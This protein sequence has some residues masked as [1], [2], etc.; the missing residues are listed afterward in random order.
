M[1]SRQ[2]LRLSS[3]SISIPSRRL[4]STPLRASQKEFNYHLFLAVPIAI[5]GLYLTTHCDTSSLPIEAIKK[6]IAAAIEADATLRGNG[7]LS[8]LYF[9]FFSFFIIIVIFDSLDI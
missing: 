5:T 2:V 7:E 8:D 4:F 6:D 9:F 3:R 1:F